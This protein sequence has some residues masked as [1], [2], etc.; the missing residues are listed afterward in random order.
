MEIK[1]IYW[2]SYFN[3]KE[4]SVRYRA[5]YPL[6]YVKENHNISYSIVFPGYDFK[7]FSNFLLT[8]F[9]ALFFRKKNSIIVFQKIFTNGIYTH[10]L[11]FLLFCR[12]QNTLYDIDDAEYTR[13]PAKAMHH[14]MK[15]CSACSAGSQ[16]ILD[17]I[18]RFNKN[19]FFLTSPVIDHGFTKTELQKTL[20][21]GWIGYYGAHRPSLTNLFFPALMKIDFPVKLILMGVANETEEIKSYFNH[22]PNI[23]IEAPLN[24]DWFDEN[25]VYEI[26]SSFDIGVS[27]LNDTDFNQG[28]SAFK[29]KQCLSCGIPV[30]GSRIGENR[31]YLQDGINGYFCDTPDEYFEKI[32]K[33]KDSKEHA[34]VLSQNAKATFPAFSIEYYCSAFLEYYNKNR[35]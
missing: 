18:S 29:L 22:N 16:T 13:R 30:L 21:I 33:I 15:K 20:T 4:P 5:K 9:S 2:F 34:R 35:I 11:K 3:L 32:N 27:P 10:A 7:N 1:H 17:Y 19:V 14:F 8:L 6:Q 26:I 23:T 25:S 12:P 31:R 24:I 28:K